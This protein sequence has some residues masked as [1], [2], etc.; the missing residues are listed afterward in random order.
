M[1]NMTVLKN[2]IINVNDTMFFL[3]DMQEKFRPAIFKFDEI[4]QICN[5]LVNKNIYKNIY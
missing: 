5:R 2:N 1:S 4:V 3:C